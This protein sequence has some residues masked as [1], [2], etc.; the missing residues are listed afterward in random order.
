MS[1][2]PIDVEWAVC[3]GTIE[4][5]IPQ[6]KLI[7]LDHAVHIGNYLLQQLRAVG[8][9]VTGVLYPLSVERGSLSVRTGDLASDDL[10]YNWVDD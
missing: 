4:V 6:R 7:Q 10:I 5:R 9:P 1:T 8:I 3:A 2:T